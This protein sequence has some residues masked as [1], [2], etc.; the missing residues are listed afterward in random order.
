MSNEYKTVP[1]ELKPCAC[2]KCGGS[3]FLPDLGISSGG[4][5]C[6][7]CGGQGILYPAVWF[8]APAPSGPHYHHPDC[9]YW[10]WDWRYSW[11]DTD[12]NCDKVVGPRNRQEMVYE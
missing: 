7:A 8:A 11:D 6:H 3:G 9:N 4:V 12:C 1:V 10:K 5:T 2:P